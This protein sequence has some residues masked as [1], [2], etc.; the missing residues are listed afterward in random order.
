[1]GFRRWC[2]VVVYPGAVAVLVGLFVFARV[3]GGFF[4]WFLFSFCLA[5]SLYEWGCWALALHGLTV[6]RKPSATRL[7][8][9]QSLRVEVVVRRHVRLWP[10]V[11][12][13]V[14]DHTPSALRAR[15][16]GARRRFVPL[17]GSMFTFT[18]EIARLPRGCYTLGPTTVTT[19]D[20][21][22]L[23]RR[24]WQASEACELLVYPK[25]L[26][27]QGWAGMRPETLGLREPT[28]QRSED[29]TTVLGVRDY[30]PGDRF[31]RI[32][33][34]A[35]ARRGH[36]QSKEFERH[37]SDDI[38]FIV[39]VS[40]G[41]YESELG[42]V[43][44]ELAMDVAASLAKHTYDL[45]RAYAWVMHGREFVA[46]ARSG[47]EAQYRNCLESLARAK[48]EGSTPFAESL[49]RVGQAAPSGA[50]LVVISPALARETAIAAGVMQGR[51]TVEWFAPLAKTALSAA[52]QEGLRLLQQAGVRVH[53]LGSTETLRHLGRGGLA[54]ANHL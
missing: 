19:V 33:W 3:Q 14:E 4:P 13:E 18:Y 34:R 42:T 7:P 9:G 49:R 50:T 29:S 41:S 20:L 24:R 36:L 5:L 28:R 15:A 10:F 8:A 37:V 26:P 46:F 6:S 22:G 47:D 45:G 12:I 2:R 48:P 17:W 32:H 30:T 11:W 27:V 38:L 43:Q 25:P 35:S 31:S 40:G 53:L 39:D 51:V 21:F 1:M 23:V 16:S 54:R 52:E 44:F